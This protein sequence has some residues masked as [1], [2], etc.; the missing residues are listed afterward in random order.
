M[1]SE[2]KSSIMT[3]I[4]LEKL[5]PPQKG[6]QIISVS[7]VENAPDKCWVAEGARIHVRVI[8]YGFKCL[9]YMLNP[10]VSLPECKK[11]DI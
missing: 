8:R 3:F 6:H 4:G 10:K 2:V 1:P 9:F 11:I 7:C 5:L